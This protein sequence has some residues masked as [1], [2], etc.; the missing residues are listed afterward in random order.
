MDFWNPKAYFFAF[1]M[2]YGLSKLQW[3]PHPSLVKSKF[4]S[5][6]LFFFTHGAPSLEFQ[7]KIHPRLAKSNYLG[8]WPFFTHG[9]PMARP[10]QGLFVSLMEL[11]ARSSIFVLVLKN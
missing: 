8:S 6:D 4:L 10:G 9:S 2:F 3:N 5:F 7:C 11:H 1:G